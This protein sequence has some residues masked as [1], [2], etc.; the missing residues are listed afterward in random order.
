MARAIRI[1]VDIDDSGGTLR[2]ISQFVTRM[3]W[4]RSAVVIDVSAVSDTFFNGITGLRDG[5]DISIETFW[6]NTA[7]TGT[8]VVLA[9]SNGSTRSVRMRIPD[10]SPSRVISAEC[11]IKT[12]DR[13]HGRG[14]AVALSVTATVVGAVTEATST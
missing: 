6:D 4:P 5:D 14:E 3:R 7:T 10:T 2:D 8:D 1:G 11:I 9:D 12:L 13:G